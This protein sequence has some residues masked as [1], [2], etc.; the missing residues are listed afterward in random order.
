[1]CLVATTFNGSI[2]IKGTSFMGMHRAPSFQEPM[3]GL[4]LCC[5]CLEILNNLKTKGPT[6]SFCTGTGKLW[7]KSSW[8]KIVL[9]NT[10]VYQ[11]KEDRL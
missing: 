2:V 10:A 8:Q 4:M 9:D 7:S 5:C 3:F 6:F 1:M 11:S